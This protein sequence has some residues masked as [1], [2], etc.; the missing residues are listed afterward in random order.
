MVELQ[1][2]I[3][4]I[5]AFIVGLLL[6]ALGVPSVTDLGVL[7]LTG[8]QNTLSNLPNVPSQAYAISGTAIF[9][10]RFLGAFLEIEVPLRLIMLFMGRGEN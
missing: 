10:L 1:A 6:S 4:E 2:V 5:I 9:A 7:I 8:F 3:P